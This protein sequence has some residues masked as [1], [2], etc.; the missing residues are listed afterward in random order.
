MSRLILD[1]N[2]L[3]YFPIL[4]RLRSGSL[5]NLEYNI[6]ANP[7]FPN[8]AILHLASNKFITVPKFIHCIKHLSSLNLSHND[9]QDIPEE[10]GL[11]NTTFITY[12]KLEGIKPRNVPES[13]MKSSSR[14]LVKYLRDLQQ[15]YCR[16][17]MP[18]P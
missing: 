18:W 17:S 14:N 1:D 4:K 7:L 11:I 15:R 8:L 16:A 3:D 10:M 2:L 6:Q 5:L 9:I 13:V 12:I